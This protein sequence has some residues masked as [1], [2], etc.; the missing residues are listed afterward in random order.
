MINKNWNKK[1]GQKYNF[2]NQIA[3]K[4]SVMIEN[5]NLNRK[6]IQW[7]IGQPEVIS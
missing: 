2:L 5:V 3:P 4:N 1:R 7:M 6:T